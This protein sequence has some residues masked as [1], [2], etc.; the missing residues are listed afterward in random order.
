ML[1]H[2]LQ[3][4]CS[5]WLLQ[6]IYWSSGI[7]L[8]IRQF[9]P[10]TWNV[11]TSKNTVIKVHTGISKGCTCRVFF[12]IK[13]VRKKCCLDSFN[14]SNCHSYWLLDLQKQRKNKI[15]FAKATLRNIIIFW[16]L[17]I[18]IVILEREGETNLSDF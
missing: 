7:T 8:T 9:L 10:Q 18:K 4:P 12:L 2:A 15:V 5:N 3:F 1:I 16:A 14:R 13:E 17:N 11:K 6:N